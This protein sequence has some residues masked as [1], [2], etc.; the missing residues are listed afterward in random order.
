MV[1]FLVKYG[2]PSSIKAMEIAKQILKAVSYLGS[3]G[4][5]H[6]DIKLDNIFYD[7]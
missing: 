4:I 2:I 1:D 6:R 5:V 3:N 7:Q